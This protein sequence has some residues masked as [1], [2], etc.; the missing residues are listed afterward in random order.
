MPL[1]RWVARA[2][3]RGLNVVARRFAGRVAPFALVLHRGR[4][5]GVAYQT[6]VMAF[7]AGGHVAIALTYGP[8][9]DWVRNVLAS[10]TCT[11]IQ[12]GRRVE[13]TDPRLVGASEGLPI[14]PILIRPPLRLLRVR[15]FLVMDRMASPNGGGMAEKAEG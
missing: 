5:S 7:G 15:E 12:R 14:L 2:N 13:T 6:P 10:R 8:D 1:P 11:L 4:R 9:A 3:R